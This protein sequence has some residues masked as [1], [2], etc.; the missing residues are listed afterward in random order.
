M[1]RNGFIRQFASKSHGVEPD[2]LSPRC[3]LSTEM[4]VRTGVSR[5][6]A[7]EGA[8]EEMVPGLSKS[9][10]Q[11]RAVKQPCVRGGKPGELQ[12]AAGFDIKTKHLWQYGFSGCATVVKDTTCSKMPVANRSI[13]VWQLFPALLVIFSF[14]VYANSNTRN[15]LV[16]DG[17]ANAH[18]PISILKSGNLR[19]NLLTLFLVSWKP[20]RLISI[21]GLLVRWR[22]QYAA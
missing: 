4:R 7:E 11:K 1:F 10:Q 21:L 2:I 3:L 14:A 17:E 22:Q 12:L 9:P 6:S 19:L 8:L 5:L 13:S 16:L 15:Y 20:S 18:I